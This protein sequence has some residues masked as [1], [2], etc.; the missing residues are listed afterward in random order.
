[1]RFGDLAAEEQADPGAACLGSEERHE[2][3][4]GVGDAMPFVVQHDFQAGKF[5]PPFQTHS[6]TQSGDAGTALQ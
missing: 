1:M 4:R 5:L 2:Q 6:R 3:I